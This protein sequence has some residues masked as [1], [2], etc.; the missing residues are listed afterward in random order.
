[1]ARRTHQSRSALCRT[2]KVLDCPDLA[3]APDRHELEFGAA[4]ALAPLPPDDRR[5]L[6]AELDVIAERDGKRPSVRE[7]EERVRC[8][9]GGA[10]AVALAPER[11]AAV[12]AARRE[13]GIAI[14]IL[15]RPG[16]RSRLEATL[17]LAEADLLWLSE[18]LTAAQ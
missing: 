2:L 11:L 17:T 5:Q 16:K 9:L 15:A 4:R 10:P 14:A 13:R 7:V 12:I 18:W 3:A 8:W 1:V 6:L